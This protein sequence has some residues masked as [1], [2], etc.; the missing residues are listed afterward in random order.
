MFKVFHEHTWYGVKDNLT[1]ATIFIY[2]TDHTPAGSTT[3]LIQAAV[4]GS[5]GQSRYTREIYPAK[6]GLGPTGNFSNNRLVPIPLQILNLNNRTA[7]HGGIGAPSTNIRVG[8]PH[9]NATKRVWWETVLTNQTFYVGNQYNG[10]DTYIDNYGGSGKRAPGF[11]AFP[12]RPF[13]SMDQASNPTLTQGGITGVAAGPLSIAL[14][15]T[16]TISGTAPDGLGLVLHTSTP[17]NA[18][19]GKPSL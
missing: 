7:F 16:V 14:N 17:P 6:E 15:N 4:T 3:S 2:D 1:Y 5:D 8:A 19:G 9:L 13:V 12:A 10:S 11:G 18:S